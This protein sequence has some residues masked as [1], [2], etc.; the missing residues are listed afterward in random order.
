ME[1][2]EYLQNKHILKKGERKIKDKSI[3]QYINRL[4][5]LRRAGIYNDEKQIDS[6]LKQKVQERYKDWKTYVT[7]IEHYLSSKKY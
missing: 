7:T 4:E 6:V 5:N 1:F 2:K 3:N